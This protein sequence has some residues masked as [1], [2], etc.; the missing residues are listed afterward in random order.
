M[1]YCR[2]SSDDYRCDA[3]AYESCY[4]GFVIHV[5][6]SKVLG[7]IPRI[8]NPPR[9]WYVEKDRSRFTRA[10]YRAGCWL[11]LLTYRLQMRYLD[12][13]PRRP[14]GLPFDGESFDAPE[15]AACADRLEW[16]RAQGYRVPQFAIDTLREEAREETP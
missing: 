6:G 12:V 5:A 10:R 1:S 14:L 16:L 7:W 9:R 2:F 15:A 8:W 4:G 3:Y 11:F 13:A